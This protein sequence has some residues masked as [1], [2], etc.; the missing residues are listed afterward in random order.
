[1]PE[2]VDIAEESKKYEDEWLVFEV[3]EVDERHW[4]VKGRLLC[5]TKSRDE[6]HEAAVK[7][8]G[9]GLGL[10]FVFAGDPVPPGMI[11]VL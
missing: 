1:M 4:P 7:H 5:H 3:V 10:R 2:I 11:A 8:R 6:V 9:A